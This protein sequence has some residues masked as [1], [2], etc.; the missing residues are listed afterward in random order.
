MDRWSVTTFT[1][2]A[3]LYGPITK[4]CEFPALFLSFYLICK[5]HELISRAQN[6]IK[7]PLVNN[8]RNTVR[9]SYFEDTSEGKKRTQRSQKL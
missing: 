4:G 1:R 9:L 2:S 8:L 6:S 3:P 5:T 7:L